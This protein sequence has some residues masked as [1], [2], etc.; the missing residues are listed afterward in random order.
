METDFHE[1]PGSRKPI[2][3]KILL[4][5]AGK[6]R[7]RLF[8]PWVKSTFN[9]KVFGFALSQNSFLS[10]FVHNKKLTNFRKCTQDFNEVTNFSNLPS[11]VSEAIK[12][13]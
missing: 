11:S 3:V 13:A 8:W 10:I 1:M 7:N 9:R 4:E 5:P 6:V 12:T 2:K